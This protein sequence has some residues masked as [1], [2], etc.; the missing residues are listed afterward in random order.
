MAYAINGERASDYMEVLVNSLSFSFVRDPTSFL[1]P[2][3]NALER[4]ASFNAKN[5]SERVCQ[6]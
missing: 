3:D 5:K 2:K 4:K 1:L 6:F